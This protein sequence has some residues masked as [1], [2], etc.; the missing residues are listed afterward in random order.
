MLGV[1]EELELRRGSSFGILRIFSWQWVHW[2]REHL[3]WDVLAFAVLAPLC[4]LRNRTETALCLLLATFTVTAAV[5]LHHPELA[6]FR[7]LSGLDSALFG[8]ACAQMLREGAARRN[9]WR[10][11]LAL[12]WAVLFVGKTVTEL[13]SGQAVFVQ[14]EGMVPLAVAHLAGFGTGAAVVLGQLRGLQRGP[15]CRAKPPGTRIVILF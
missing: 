3:F 2:S 1:Q 7:G 15:L 11:G 12:G 10:T 4:E 13:V 14:T 9:R 8:L 5:S 6:R